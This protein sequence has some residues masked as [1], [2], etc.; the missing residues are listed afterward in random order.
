MKGIKQLLL[1]LAVV[2]LVGCGKK[3]DSN[4]GVINP[5]KPAPKAIPVNIDNPIVEE[6]IR[7][8]LKKPTGALTQ[9]DLENMTKL[10]LHYNQ[11]TEVPKGLEKL[12]KA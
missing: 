6:A 5:N 2:V 7:E 12:T 1:I 9:V 4:T 11:L 8:Q 3:G 10:S